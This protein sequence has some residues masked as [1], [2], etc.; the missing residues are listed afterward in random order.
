MTSSF[1][2]VLILPQVFIEITVVLLKMSDPHEGAYIVTVTQKA[3]RLLA[4]CEVRGR[5]P[6]YI[7]D[8][9]ATCL[10]L[11]CKVPTLHHWFPISLFTKYTSN[12]PDTKRYCI[13][14]LYCVCFCLNFV[15][16][17]M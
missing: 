2:L 16:I 10:F 6:A 3:E 9:Q 14:T 13:K 15:M 12:C 1:F 7:P 4:V 8:V 17:L 11:G 5:V